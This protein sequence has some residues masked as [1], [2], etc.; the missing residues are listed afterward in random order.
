MS[1]S[2]A[3]NDTHQ[4]FLVQYHSKWMA[5]I[6]Q[7]YFTGKYLLMALHTDICAISLRNS[8]ARY[9]THAACIYVPGYTSCHN[10]N[11]G[12]VKTMYYTIH[13]H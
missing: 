11:V 8:T 5:T 10:W 13:L 1:I 4:H 9:Q 2:N 7:Q 6:S 12:P 3:H